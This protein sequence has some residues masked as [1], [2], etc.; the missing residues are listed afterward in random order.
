LLGDGVV[1]RL[2]LLVFPIIVGDGKRLF[3]TGR[4]RVSL[5]LTDTHVFHNGVVKLVYTPT[6]E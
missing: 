4:D 2:V 1:D 6:N 3:A 5:S